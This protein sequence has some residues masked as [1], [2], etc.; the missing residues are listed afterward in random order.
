MKPEEIK[1]LL[2]HQTLKMASEVYGRLEL[3]QKRKLQKRV[4]SF[5]K[6]QGSAESKGSRKI[7][8]ILRKAS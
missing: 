6:K 7:V 2:R 4:I 8:S 3:E 1:T 5:V